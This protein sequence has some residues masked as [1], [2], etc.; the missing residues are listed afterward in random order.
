MPKTLSKP[1]WL[2]A[3]NKTPGQTELLIYGP[4]G[5]T[6]DESGTTFAQFRDQWSQI[7]PGD[8]ITLRVNSAGGS[9]W[10]GMPI[11]NLIRERRADV[12]AHVEAVAASIASVIIMGAGR[13]VM[14][15]QGE[16][17]IHDPWTVTSGDA[18]THESS[19]ARLN[20]LGEQIATLYAQRTGK[21]PEE[22]RALMKANGVG[23][24]FFGQAAKDAGLIDD[25]APGDPAK[26]DFDLSRFRPAKTPTGGVLPPPTDKHKQ[27]VSDMETTNAP[28]PPAGATPNAAASTPQPQP[29]TPAAPSD[30]VS[31]A[32]FNRVKALLA[33]ETR[34][35]IEARLNALAAE[36]D[37][38]P[39]DWLDDCVR[40][41]TVLDRLAKLPT[42]GTA[43][44]GGS[45]SNQGNAMVEKFRGLKPGAERKAFMVENH[46]EIVR[47]LTLHTPQA[48]NTLSSTV[49]PAYLADGLIVAV[50]NRLAM[51][52]AFTADFTESRIAPRSTVVVKK[53]TAGGTTQTN[54]TNFES[55]DS[56][57][58]AVSITMN[59]YSQSFHIDNDALNQGFRLADIAEYNGYKLSDKLSDVVTAL[60][61][62]G[63]T[64]ANG[65][66][67]TTAIGAA[68]SFDAADLPAIYALAKNFTRKTLVLDGGH[69]AY[70]IP[71]DKNKFTIGESGAYGFDAIYENNRWTSAVSN[72][73]GFITDRFGIAVASGLPVARPAQQYES[74]GTAVLTKGGLTVET[75]TW[76]NTATRI[77][78]AGMDVVFGAQVG[79][80]AAT[81][82]L[83]LL[84]TS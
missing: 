24:S 54:A 71:T 8:K 39:A 69:I 57:V 38:T 64:E 48:G 1:P 22:M 62:V 28:T 44:I 23:T 7:P 58:D 73:V 78:W 41:E 30:V 82:A 37:I 27:K 74:L 34:K 46:R 66:G 35:R 51:L 4:I 32:E 20:F 14:P 2:L 77:L 61:V 9:I 70:L 55:G 81:G 47:N 63:S 10:D 19:V 65:F 80:G 26:N 49:V 21:T 79:N 59:Q 67:A 13:I 84:V 29:S 83:R 50:H 3:T 25:I 42:R 53:T 75:S 5:E 18:A 76:Y 36:R 12:T 56:T 68:A 15:A 45:I 31:I 6:W 40:D 33:M 43:P 16:I 52:D 11:Y 72:C 17:F 60:L